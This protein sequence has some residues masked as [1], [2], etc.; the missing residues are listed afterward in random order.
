MKSRLSI[1]R[2]VS[3]LL[4]LTM[5]PLAAVA[6]EAL[7]SYARYV[8]K[9]SDTTTIYQDNGDGTRTA[10]G[11]IA[12]GTYVYIDHTFEGQ[13]DHVKYASIVALDGTRGEVTSAKLVSAMVWIGNDSYHELY[14][15]E[16]GMPDA[17]GNMPHDP[18]E[19]DL[20]SDGAPGGTR[21]MAGTQSSGASGSSA[22][23]TGIPLNA[24]V[25]RVSG[26]E[27]PEDMLV[28]FVYA[29]SS[30][31]ATIREAANNDSQALAQCGAGTV[32]TVLEVGATHTL[33]DADGQ[34]GYLRNDCLH[35]TAIPP[36]QRLQ[37][38]LIGNQNINVRSDAD[39]ESC[40]IAQWPAGTQVTV[41]GVEGNW[42]EVEYDGMH[43]WVATK[44]IITD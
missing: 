39:K 15:K 10:S 40:R 35:Y 14:L 30:G 28:A 5:I 18:G 11:T 2:A 32:V 16:H 8:W 29:P 31:K 1:L 44:Y 41:Y 38:T 7:P 27:T 26:K 19:N 13:D 20:P 3:A 43:G 25:R 34:S 21:A 12:G 22:N 9:I 23:N 4:L 36:E 33:V 42:C 6:E 37:G 24:K 17:V